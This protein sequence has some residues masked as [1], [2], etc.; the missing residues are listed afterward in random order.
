MTEKLIPQHDYILAVEVKERELR[1]SKSGLVLP[2]VSGETAYNRTTGLLRAVEVGPG[3]WA[4]TDT[5]FHR[6]PMSVKPGD[7]FYFGGKCPAVV[8]NGDLYVLAQDHQVLAVLEGAEFKT[9]EHNNIVR[10]S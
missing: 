5:G 6:K 1:P 3:P 10:L 7:L 2:A 4:L 9:D 8:V